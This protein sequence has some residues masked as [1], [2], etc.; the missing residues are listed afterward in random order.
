MA[1]SYELPQSII[2]VINLMKIII[3]GGHLTPALALIDFIQQHHPSDE[4][5]FVGRMYS[6]DKFKQLAQEKSE[7]EQRRLKFIHLKAI[8][9]AT[10]QSILKKI[11]FPLTFIHSIL[12]ALKIMKREKPNILLSF[13]GYVAIPLAIT[14]KLTRVKI[15]THEQ[16]RATGFANQF[17]A[18]L[19][20]K[21]AISF[22]D[23][24]AYFPQIK[25]HLT[26]NPIR[27]KLLKPK[28]PRPKWLPDKIA[29]P[30]LLIIG[31]SQ[32]SATI[33]Q[34]VELALP[35]LTKNWFIIHLCG[36]SNNQFDYQ[37]QLNKARQKLPQDQQQQYVVRKWANDTELAWIYSHAHAAV[38]RAGANTVME[39]TVK[40]IPSLFIPLIHSHHD[41]QLKNA[42]ELQKQAA[43]LLLPQQELNSKTLT[44]QLRQLAIHHAEL[45][46]N[47]K[48][49]KFDLQATEKIYQLMQNLTHA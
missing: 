6:Q 42:L 23:S 35:Q 14:A 34:A 27:S 28:P 32:G 3:S 4:I 41:E 48:K 22:P 26:G 38:S 11:I 17:I 15:I 43:A 39:L 45:K 8:K 2:N 18:K 13:G 47:L 25:T 21:V 33:N 40:Q 5:V 36:N 10:H 7:I 49:I 46:N 37:K 30:I 12:S 44:A 9:T 16:T 31:G 19:A 20:D 29:S 1:F 24:R